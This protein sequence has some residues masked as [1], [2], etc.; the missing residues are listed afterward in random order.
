MYVQHIIFCLLFAT[1]LWCMENPWDNDTPIHQAVHRENQSLEIIVKENNATIEQTL[2]ELKNVPSEPQFE[3]ISRASFN[4]TLSQIEYELEKKLDP[5]NP[6]DI[7]IIQK[8]HDEKIPDLR[9]RNRSS[10]EV[11]PIK[12]LDEKKIDINV[13]PIVMLLEPPLLE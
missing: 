10:D 11:P 3:D 4:N 9:K 6:K 8:L 12:I 5:N 13:P 1:S 7:K 2:Q